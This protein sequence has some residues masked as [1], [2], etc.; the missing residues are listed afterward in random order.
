MRLQIEFQIRVDRM[1]G[2]EEYARIRRIRNGQ[3]RNEKAKSWGESSCWLL[4]VKRDIWRE[5][6]MGQT[7]RM[8]GEA[9]RIRR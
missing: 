9:G 3:K 5:D 6:E 8:R 2:G 7:R 4:M 1:G